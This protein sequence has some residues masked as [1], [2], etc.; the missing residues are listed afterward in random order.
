MTSSIPI[1]AFL[2]YFVDEFLINGWI[3]N[4]CRE[5]LEKM[6]KVK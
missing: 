6:T 4:S 2:T 3:A 1:A 5:K